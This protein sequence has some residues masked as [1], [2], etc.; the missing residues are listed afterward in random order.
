MDRLSGDYNKGY[1]K[2]I[3]D[4]T[5]IF[6]Y[7]QSDL[8]HHKIR[9]TDKIVAKLLQR[10]L[11]EREKIRDDWDGFMRWNSQKEDFEWFNPKNAPESEITPPVKISE[12]LFAEFRMADGCLS[13]ETPRC[14]GD[15]ESAKHCQTFTDWIREN[16]HG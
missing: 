16:N 2:A 1:T 9:M 12:E 8:T 10:C 4:I 7:I 14:M 3:Q 15:Y 11:A 6:G 5:K 13:C